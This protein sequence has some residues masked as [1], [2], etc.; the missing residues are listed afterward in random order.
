LIE[1][2]ESEL[3]DENE[4][5]VIKNVETRYRESPFVMKMRGTWANIPK[6]AW[7]EIV[8]IGIE[9]TSSCRAAETP[10]TMRE[11]K[12]FEKPQLVKG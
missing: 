5:E 12:D 3:N 1:E 4:S 7:K 8:P 10:N 9:M 6:N 11:E 2:C